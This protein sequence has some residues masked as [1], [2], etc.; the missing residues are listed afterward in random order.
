MK[1]VKIAVTGGAGSICY[2]LLF[3]LLSGEL[4]GK[5]TYIDLSILEIKESMQ[6]LKGVEMEIFDCAFPLLHSLTCTSLEDQAFEGAQFVF[7]VGAKPRSKGMERKDLLKENGKIFAHQG[8]ALNREKGA[9][10]LV[11]GN[12]CNTNALILKHAAKDLDPKNIRAMTRLDQNRA[13]AL[14]SKKANVSISSIKNLTIFGN[15]S[16]TMVSDYFHALID[17]KKAMDI[18]DDPLFFQDTLFKGVQQRGAKVI[19][20]SGAS[21]AAS[22]AN[23]A[24]DAMKDWIFPNS[25]ITSAAIYSNGNPYGITDDL[26]FSFPIKDGDIVTWQM[27]P[28]L[29]KQIK[30]TEKELLEERVN[31]KLIRPWIPIVRERIRIKREAEAAQLLRENQDAG[32]QAS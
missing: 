30:I 27:D 31:A 7:L 11:V 28:F 12:P 3:R 14:L 2:S 22:A 1:K 6:V 5:D 15:H 21:S 8:K 17:G 16:S 24:I 20:A 25:E 23:A 19:E 18:I 29:E 13:R 9:K 10:I 32:V 26:F 4:F